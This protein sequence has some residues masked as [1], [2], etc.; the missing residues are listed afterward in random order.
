M[1]KK[2][3]LIGTDKRQKYLLELLQQRG[4]FAE[5]SEDIDNAVIDRYDAILLPVTDSK[6]YYEKI[7][8][9]LNKQQYVFGCN[10][11]ENAKLIEYMGRK[12]AAVQNAAATAEGAIAE[13]IIN[14]DVNIC[15]SKS[16][17]LG[18]GICGRQIADRLAAL[19]SSVSVIESDKILCAEAEARGFTVVDSGISAHLQ[20]MGKRYRF[21]I[22]TIP[23][24]VLDKRVLNMLRADITIIDIA[25]K[26]GGVDYEYCKS[27][28]IR[29]VHALGL[30][31]KYSPETSA[32]ILL[33]VIEKTML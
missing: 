16:L 9:R 7:K 26:P 13:A 5:L 4:H 18:Y 15:G 12:Q 6:Y 31:G 30:P 8:G 21:I 23:E 25:S 19:H 27:H 24:M 14:S 11:G 33:N 1:R 20:K 28:N 32:E 3:L 2:F 17:V 10:L 22:N 29:A